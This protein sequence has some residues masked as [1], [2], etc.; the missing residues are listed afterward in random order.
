VTD[1]LRWKSLDISQL[2][3]LV[4]RA[5]Y[6]PSPDLRGQVIDGAVLAFIVF[7]T[8]SITAAQ[9]AILLA[10][11]AWAVTLVWS[12]E[13][14]RLY[15]PL[16]V[17]MAAFF[18]A[19]VLATLTAVDPYRSLRELRNV[20]QPAFFFLLV[21][22]LAG[23]KRALR[24]TQILILTGCVMALYGLS[25]SL[26]QGEAFRIRGTMSIWMTFAG[27]MMV[28]ATLSLAHLLFT[29]S[30]RSS[31]W[32]IPALLLLVAALVMTQTRG[33]WLGFA[34]GAALV[35]VCRKRLFL[36]LLPVLALTIFVAA[37]H[38]VKERIRSI[39]DPHDVTARERLYMW[40]SGLQMIRDRPWTG[41][42]LNGVKGVYPA[43][44]DPRATGARWGHL[45]NNLI[46]VAVERGLIGLACWLW[47]WA[48]FYSAAWRTHR[49]LEDGSGA[50][51][52]LVIGALAAVTAF[53][54]EGLFEYTFGDSEV[55]T[56]VYFL[57]ALPYIVRRR[58]LSGAAGAAVADP[59]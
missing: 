2:R 34:A 28:L 31:S 26:V 10:L 39:A 7:S 59:R 35:L 9:G 17:P 49:T 52:A 40:G 14:R 53:H 55:I 16:I 12:Q 6:L 4:R 5:T 11:S 1:L 3:A 33:A 54:V 18:L 8:V 27:I 44:R 29:P 50:A 56:L 20:F 38:V 21:N 22:H 32:L 47:M 45:H 43:Y 13:R 58:C 30:R 37:P 23:E 19:S 51:K 24:L 41:V 36:L 48:A 57:M 25:Q 46:Q 42:G 15:L